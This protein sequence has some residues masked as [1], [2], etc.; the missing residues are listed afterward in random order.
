MTKTARTNRKRPRGRPG[1]EGIALV[2]VLGFLVVL[3]MLAV[4]F[5]VTMRIERLSSDT[6]LHGTRARQFVHVGLARAM[7]HIDNDMVSNNQ[8]YPEGQPAGSFIYRSSGPT[9]PAPALLANGQQA[10]DYIP[11]PLPNDRNAGWVLI[12]ED[13]ANAGSRVIGRFAWIAVDCSGLLDANTAGGAD[14]R[15]IGL[16]PGEV[17]LNHPTL[18][19]INSEANVNNFLA[20][21]ESPWRRIETLA[22]LRHVPGITGDIRTLFPYSLA[23][24][25]YFHRADGEA[26]EPVFIGGNAADIDWVEVRRQFEAMGAPDPS[27]MRD[28][29]RFYLGQTPSPRPLNT[30]ATERIPMINEVAVD[31]RWNVDGDNVVLEARVRVELW[32]PF[33]GSDPNTNAYALAIQPAFVGGGFPQPD[34][35]AAQVVPQPAGGWDATGTDSGQFG[36]VAFTFQSSAEVIPDPDGGPPALPQFPTG[37]SFANVTLHQGANQAGPAVD[38]IGPFAIDWAN[39][40]VRRTDPPATS[41]GSRWEVDDPRINWSW[42]QHWAVAEARVPDTGGNLEQ[43]NDRVSYGAPDSDGTWHMYVRG[44]DNLET[45]G[46]LGFLLFFAN[47]PWRTLPLGGAIRLREVMDRF[48]TV[49]PGTL[50]HGLVNPSTPHRAALLAAFLDAPAER[51]PGEPDP[52]RLNLDQ[53]VAVAQRLY[54]ARPFTNLSDVGEHIAA[55][56]PELTLLQRKGVIRNSAGLLS[57]RQNLLTIVVAAQSVLPGSGGDVTV[58]GESRAVF[59]VWRDPYDMNIGGADVNRSFVR[60]FRWLDAP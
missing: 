49:E 4:S 30:F 51:W 40:F 29:L 11:R 15:G 60:F 19:E 38:A 41:I 57:P 20:D 59:V 36:V 27:A 56:L 53:A 31:T 34:A 2:I 37:L 16:D 58:V 24:T 17:R 13:P 1:R 7:A 10:L 54:D 26:R 32:Y 55:A 50:R 33:V 52:E 6:Y 23:P 35:P 14:E 44:E 18:P 39:H 9:N 3:T 22:E 48:T 43:I 45:V 25:G 47:W 5:A 42:D 28:G 12:R 8:F 46:E 21:R